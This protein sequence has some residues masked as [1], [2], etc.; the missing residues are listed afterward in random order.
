MA[1]SAAIDTHVVLGYVGGWGS[2]REAMKVLRK[3]LGFDLQ[4][5]PSVLL[6][7][8]LSQDQPQGLIKSIGA[9]SIE[10]IESGL[11]EP[12]TLDETDTRIIESRVDRL[13]EIEAIPGAKKAD[14]RVLVESAY[15]G[16]DLLVTTN[17][18]LTNCDKRRLNDALLKCGVS[19]I[20]IRESREIVKQ[21]E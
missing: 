1:K 16:N 6:E 4:V 8:E 3:A 20:W 19:P 18:I 17:P 15:L 5:P 7:L 14:L 21:V 12:C 13:M 10:A 9:D 2:H 11:F